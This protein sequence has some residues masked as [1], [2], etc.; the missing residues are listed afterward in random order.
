MNLSILFL[1]KKKKE[2][3]CFDPNKNLNYYFF[4][5]HTKNL[6]CPNPKVP[7]PKLHQ[8]P[9]QIWIFASLLA[10]QFHY[11]FF[12]YLVN[13]PLKKIKLFVDL[14]FG[15]TKQKS[16]NKSEISSEEKN[17]SNQGTE[18]REGSYLQDVGP[19]LFRGCQTRWVDGSGKMETCVFMLCPKVGPGL[20]EMGTC[21]FW[22]VP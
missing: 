14:G 19:R 18:L 5:Q 10:F 2:I 16:R 13:I 22:F 1:K 21:V 15:P 7:N 6:N 8:G 11:S 17:R 3:N 12:L 9:K 20:G 4:F